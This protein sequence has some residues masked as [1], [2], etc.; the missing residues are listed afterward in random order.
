MSDETS[1]PGSNMSSRGR[2]RGAST[3]AS[4]AGGVSRR[5]LVRAAGAGA[6]VVGGGGLLEACSSSSK[7]GRGDSTSGCSPGLVIGPSGD[8]TGAADTA[9]INAAAGTGGTALLKNGTYYV[10]H[11]LPD[12][13]GAIL[14]TG[15]NTI[16]QA[17]SGTTGYAI[18]LRRPA[19]TQQVMLAGFTLK[20][21][22]GTLGGIQIDNTGYGTE[23]DPQHT[24]ENI[25]VL[26]AG[27]DGFR[28]GAN[29]RSMR[30]TNCRQYKAGG[31]G[32]WLEVGCTD[33]AFTGCISGASAGHA[34][35]VAGWNN[36]FACCKGFYAGWNGSAFDTWHNAWE[37]TGDYNTL[38]SCSAQNGA[39]H[40]FD[41]NGCSNVALAGCCADV[42]NSGGGSGVGINI[43]GALNCTIVGCTGDN[44]GGT[45]QLYGLQVAGTQANTT[46]FANTV[47]GSKAAV[48]HVSGAGY[49]LFG[50]FDADFSGIPDSVKFG[51]VDIKVA[52]AGLRVREGTNC[53]QGTAV[54]VA[55]TVTVADTAVT[56][57][58]RIFLTGQADGGTP[59]FL[60]VSARIAGKSFTIT[61]SSA[62]DT[63]TV[64][65]EIFEP[66]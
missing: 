18:A 50:P 29:S 6:A 48:N 38:T 23:S 32:F 54:L 46:V 64:A 33:N 31:A 44:R 19:S 51:N 37:I 14:G 24:L 66:G 35:N 39:L 7:G 57:S 41:L 56:A 47:T 21:N 58:S 30:V 3:L 2:L 53:K 43:H 40:G 15:S 12:S 59:G 62:T 36:F 10:T 27:G 8:A 4:T 26:G 5:G 52:G 34:W 65:Y 17:V 63:S 55:G 45:G 60:R 9:A 11:L 28:F 16:L 22:T 1:Q 42:N 49:S 13:Y 61:S 25:Y 20:A